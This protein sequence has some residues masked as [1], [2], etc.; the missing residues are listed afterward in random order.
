MPPRMFAMAKWQE[1]ERHNH[2]SPVE[3]SKS[4]SFASHIPGKAHT[5]SLWCMQ[6]QAP[7]QASDSKCHLAS[8]SLVGCPCLPTAWELPRLTHPWFLRM[9]IRAQGRVDKMWRKRR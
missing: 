6:G 5:S 2:E 3:T 4:A 8:Y 9:C 7:V 1:G